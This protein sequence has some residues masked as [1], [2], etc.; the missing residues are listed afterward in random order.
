VT[1]LSLQVHVNVL[2]SSLP[3]MEPSRGAFL[4]M[5]VLEPLML[6]FLSLS[7]RVICVTTDGPCILC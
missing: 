5:S 3:G 6:C 2:H 4:R 1:D 7:Q